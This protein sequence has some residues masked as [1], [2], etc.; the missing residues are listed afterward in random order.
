MHYNFLG[1][2]SSWF[3]G[4]GAFVNTFQSL[5]ISLG[6][7]WCIRT[8]SFFSNSVRDYIEPKNRMFHSNRF[9]KGFQY[10]P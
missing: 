10:K 6:Q 9:Y 5:S 3:V 1:L 7:E 8:E 4:H 2:L